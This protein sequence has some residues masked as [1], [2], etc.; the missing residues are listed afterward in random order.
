MFKLLMAMSL[1]AA[2]FGAVARHGTIN[3]TEGQV[4]L[5]GQAVAK[6]SLGNLEVAPG[7]VL[8]TGRGKAEVLLTPGVFLRL[9]DDSAVRMVSGSLTDTRVELVRGKALLEV[10]MIEKENRLLVRDRGTNV[11]IAKRGIYAFDAEQPRVAVYDGKAKVLVD[12]REVEVGKGKQLP[13]DSSAGLK[14]Q[15]FDRKETDDLYAWS[16][17]RSQYLAEANAS[18]VQT[19]VASNPSWWAGTGWYWNPWFGTWSFIPA[20]GFYDNP[21]G[22]GF[23]SPRYW[24]YNPPVYYYSRPVPGWTGTGG[25]TVVRQAPPMVRPGGRGAAAPRATTPAPAPAGGNSVRFGRGR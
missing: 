6:K 9:G 23:Y 19:V 15:K 10:A 4:T 12:D 13:L 2:G 20:T 17:L 3:Y 14:P 1:A 7:H 5:E 11:L 22:F 18:S 25:R 16:K 24:A 21:W 8:R